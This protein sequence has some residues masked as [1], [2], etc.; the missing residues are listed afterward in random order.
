MFPRGFRATVMQRM[1]LWGA[2]LAFLGALSLTVEAIDDHKQTDAQTR[3]DRLT[4]A[5]NATFPL[6]NLFASGRGAGAD[7]PGGAASATLDKIGDAFHA[8]AADRPTA[9][10]GD[11][12]LTSA[13]ELDRLR[14]AIAGGD[15]GRISAAW[16]ALTD[17]RVALG[18]AL[19]AG[20]DDLRGEAA[21]HLQASRRNKLLLG[22]LTLF[23]MLQIAFLEYRWLVRPISRLASSLDEGA[24]SSAAIHGDAMRRD[25][26]GSLAQAVIRHFAL[27]KRQEAAARDEKTAMSQRI[28]RQEEINQANLL[29]QNR[30]AD[31][32]Q[33]L[34]NNA[35]QMADA[36]RHLA[37]LSREID[38]RAG[39]AARSTQAASG[40]VDQVAASIVD[41]VGALAQMSAEAGRTSSVAIDAKGLVQSASDEA[42]ALAGAVA[43]IE[44]VV[45]LIQDV[46]SQTNLLSLNAT[47]EAARV[48]AA[49]RGFAIVAS[50]VKQLAMRTSAAT[51]DVRVNLEAVQ[52]ASA[53]IAGRVGALVRSIEEIDS[54]AG[55]I[56]GLMRSQEA[57]AQAISSNTEGSA[58]DVRS[59]AEKVDRVAVMIAD[60]N[61][62]A[63]L[64][65]NVSADMNVGAADLRG[66]VEEYLQTVRER[67]A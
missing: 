30:V 64:V 38:G 1:A 12:A 22:G 3:L 35:G 2:M 66:I 58:S 60:A 11:L 21:A 50:E 20:L 47:I 32:A 37:G 57:S 45:A 62:A 9:A 33:R 5:L 42:A 34:E 13:A 36:S 43:A 49:G 24:E 55:A 54:A 14:A 19:A 29:F 26:I 61:S 15:A 4:R 51:N 7:L 56:A 40:H 23:L 67:A 39:E 8:I 28:A 25:E 65:S 6:A 52:S 46:A 53:R 18:A 17:S 44:Q 10:S 16:N 31:I 48:G 63:D 59:V 41:I 27:L